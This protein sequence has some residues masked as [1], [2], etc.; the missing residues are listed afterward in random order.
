MPREL[1]L[2]LRRL[3]VDLP[4]ALAEIL[5]PAYVL[6]A[7]GEIRW[8]NAAA[9]EAFGD[10]RGEHFASVVAPETES[11]VRQ[12]FARKIRGDVRATSYEAVLIGREGR[13]FVADIDSVRLEDQGVLVGTFGVVELVRPVD[14]DAAKAVR[15][16]P[17]Q[18]EVLQLLAGGCSTDRIA[19]QLHVSKETARNHI[20]HTL[21][22]L[23]AHSRLEAVARARELGIV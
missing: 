18:L 13:R 23:H 4:K 17:R 2:A 10:Q 22:A 20:K 7:R 6:S 8:M 14:A 21:R 3:S 11:V 9:V 1:A 16:T 19:S 12:Q 5:I 15:L